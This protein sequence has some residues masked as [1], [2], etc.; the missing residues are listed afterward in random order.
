MS[1]AIPQRIADRLG[2]DHIAYILRLDRPQGF[3]LGRIAGNW[4]ANECE[5]QA[6][7]EALL[8]VLD[9]RSDRPATWTR[10]WYAYFRGWTD[11]MGRGRGENPDPR[12]ILKGR[13][14]EWKDGYLVFSDR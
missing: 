5:S 13:P 4:D 8:D 9:D 10:Q 1:N 14:V 2:S 3:I 11:V 12:M 7:Y 6:A